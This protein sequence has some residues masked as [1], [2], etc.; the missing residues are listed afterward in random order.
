MGV[1]KECYNQ[2]DVQAVRI[3]KHYLYDI[4]YNRKRNVS[5]TF[6]L[7]L[8]LMLHPLGIGD[9]HGMSESLVFISGFGGGEPLR[10][11]MIFKRCA[12]RPLLP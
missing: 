6:S 5:S 7:K 1:E 8:M 9:I 3:N 2:K 12:S 10:L 11:W 4:N